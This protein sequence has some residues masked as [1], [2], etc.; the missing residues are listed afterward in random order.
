MGRLAHRGYAEAGTSLERT[1]G[2]S[3]NYFR[4]QPVRIGPGA[5][6]GS[7]ELGPRRSEDPTA[8][9]SR[10]R[11]RDPSGCC[12][13]RRVLF[14]TIWSR[15]HI[16]RSL[17][18]TTSKYQQIPMPTGS[19]CV[20]GLSCVT[21][22]HTSPKSSPHAGSRSLHQGRA[23]AGAVTIIHRGQPLRAQL[24]RRSPPIRRPCCFS[25]RAATPPA[26]CRSGSCP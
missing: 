15:L 26:R 11:G 21:S 3:L 4:S 24:T 5:D 12:L 13:G 7:K 20:N 8:D 14:C 9:A 19:I 10:A 6:V 22:L 1:R 2:V 25:T 23:C 16:W 17:C 18:R